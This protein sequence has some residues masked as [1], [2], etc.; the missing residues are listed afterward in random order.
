MKIT[1]KP[2]FCR[3][4]TKSE[5]HASV[6]KISELMDRG[7]SLSK[8]END[9]LDLLGT[10][11]EDYEKRMAPEVYEEIRNPVS[12]I[13]ALAW[14]MDKHGLKQ[15]D[16]CPYIGSEPLVSAVM[17]GTRSLSKTM[18]VNL[19]EG[20]G[21]PYEDLLAPSDESRRYRKVAML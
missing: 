14:T 7:D 4:K 8:A 17:N 18:I 16:L 2:F 6:K 15:K 12:P 21:I 5:Y 10:L 19:H 20:L 11:V 1:L 3:I 13:E 9:Y